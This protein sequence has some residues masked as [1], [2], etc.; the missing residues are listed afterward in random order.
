PKTRPLTLRG[1]SFAFSLFVFFCMSAPLPALAQCTYPESFGNPTVNTS[2]I[3]A[4]QFLPASPVTL[5]SPATVTSMAEYL[6][7]ASGQLQ[8]AIYSDNGNTPGTLVVQ[9]TAQT[10]VPNA[11]NTIGVSVTL[12]GGTY[13][14]AGAES[15]NANAMPGNTMDGRLAYTSLGYTFGSLPTSYPSPS[16]QTG[17][18]AILLNFCSSTFIG[19]QTSTPTTTPS[20]TPTS[21]STPFY[22]YTP[23]PTDTPPC[24][25]AFGVFGSTATTTSGYIGSGQA[26]GSL[27]TLSEPGTV[28]ALSGYFN[29]VDPT[30][31]IQFAIYRNN[32][33][34]VSTLVVQSG[35][36]Q[37]FN[38][39]NSISVPP[40]LL[41]PGS[42]WLFFQETT[43]GK[44]YNGNQSGPVSAEAYCFGCA[45]LGNF[46]TNFT[47]IG[48]SNMDDSMVAA[49]CPV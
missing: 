48:F 16:L 17:T 23:N 20:M 3:E 1:L 29:P 30:T 24:A 27:Y 25:P 33:G 39:W 19:T 41:N 4:S 44:V 46:P 42:Y 8:L 36:Q 38:G 5:S 2:N 14:L 31:Q 34:A 9:T 37:A 12:S 40:T 15:V 28:T 47:P 49:Y 35:T 11:W 6:G 13:W 7:P 26:R 45:S 43:A 10:A 18:V 21:T 32:A 22:T